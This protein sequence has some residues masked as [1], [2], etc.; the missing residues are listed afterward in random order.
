MVKLL[1]L[2]KIIKYIKDNYKID[3]FLHISNYYKIL[4][5]IKNY[6]FCK[7]K[8]FVLNDFAE[9]QLYKVIKIYTGYS[10]NRIIELIAYIN[11]YN[12]DNFKF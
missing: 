11:I 6:R 9:Q 10:E 7:L 4:H 5:Y 2:I 8:Y 1:L 12:I 3:Y